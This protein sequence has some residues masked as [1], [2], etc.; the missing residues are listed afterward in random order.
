MRIHDHDIAVCSWSLRPKNM[1]E[2]VQM[3]QGLGLQ[4]IQLGLL[5][6]IQTDDSKRKSELDVLR[7]SGIAF[8]GGMMSFPGEDYSTIDAICHT[9]GFVPD[10]LWDERK[11]LCA[12]AASVAPEL[13]INQIGTHIG[14]VPPKG[15]PGYQRMIDRVTQIATIFAEKKIELLMETGQENANELL[16]FLHDLDAP[17]VHINFDPANMILYGAG[18]PIASV[19]VLGNHIR[20]VHVKDATSSGTPGVQW[21]AEVPFGTG[22]VGASAFLSALRQNG[23]S[24]PLAIEREAGDDRMGDVK[25]AIAS[26]T[27]AC[28]A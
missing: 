24:G 1:H 8:T 28:V 14:F 20:H 4:H 18:D 15:E 22:Q 16:E 3:V 25:H 10:K 2:L 17:T 12:R 11:T 21:G 9:G 5:E 19:H 13:G 6:L 23:Y 26:L 27:D 7:R